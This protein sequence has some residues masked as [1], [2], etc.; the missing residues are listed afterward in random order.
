MAGLAPRV[1]YLAGFGFPVGGL[2]A[3]KPRVLRLGAE[4]L[5]STGRELVYV[6][7]S[8]GRQLTAVYRFPGQ[9][10][11]LEVLA[12]R[13]VLFVLCAWRGVYCL[14]LDQASRSVSQSDGDEEERGLPSPAVPVDP[15][16][17]VLPDA[18]LCAFTVMDGVLI[19]LAQG[20]AQ[21]KLQVF[22]CP[23]PG[24]ARPLDQIG[25]VQLSAC[26]PP[27]GSPGRPEAPSPRFLPVLCCVS[28][29]GCGAPHSL[30][31]GPPGSTL[32]GA[33]FGLLFGT[34][35]TLLESPVILCGLPD[36]QL[37]SVVLKT[38]VT[39]RSA[40]GD[41][42]ALVR[43]LHH[44]EEPVIF[45][46]ALRT[47][48]LP[49]DMEDTCCD[50]LVALGHRG[51]TLAIKASWDEAGSLVPE[52]REYRLPGP[53]LCAAC[54]EGGRVYHSTP[55]S[56]CLVDLARGGTPWLGEGA[57]VPPNGPGGLPSLLCPASLSVCSVVTLSVSPRLPE[58]G[59]ELLALSARGR[60][61][62]CRLEQS[63]EAPWPTRGT[64]AA[65]GRRMKDLLCGIGT[66]SERV[67]SL[68][69]AVDQRNRA[70]TCLN[71]AMNV[72]CALLSCR[73]GPRP[74]S[75][76]T[77][78]AWSRRE[79]RDVLTATCLLEN[80][81]GP[82]L[83]RGWALCV[84]VL[85]G[86]PAS[87]PEAAGSAVTYTIPVDQL[88]PGGRREVTLALG[89]GK[90]GMLD[91]PV[92]V[93]CALFY[94]LREVLGGALAPSGSSEDASW[95]GQEGICLPLS[96]HTVDL[97]QGLRFPGLATSL[98]QALGPS[99]PTLDPVDTFLEACHR[100]GSHPAQPESLR[101]KYLPPSVA[102]ITVSAELL[103]AAC[104][105]RSSGMS[106]SCAVLQ[107]LL[108]ENAVVDVVRARGLSSVQGVAP[109]GTD[110]RLTVR[111]VAVTGMCPAG[112]LQ[113]AEIQV[114]SRCLASVCGAHGA[115]VRRMQRGLHKGLT[116]DLL[117]PAAGPQSCPP[118]VKTHSLSSDKG[119]RPVLVVGQ[120][121]T[122]TSPG[123]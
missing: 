32:E 18:T 31:Q 64:S 51:R 121:V 91:L 72:S 62:T 1:D 97:L 106:L 17:C 113:A 86:A 104:G 24:Q 52:M 38:L 20:T 33:L 42:K 99:G 10:C 14:S 76:T 65:T 93:C 68:K 53:L 59:A 61:L 98:A 39:S 82:H 43:I 78:T 63:P 107:W 22:Q 117:A 50:C 81:S 56:L 58:G 15:D 114:E 108:A 40:P 11:H 55:S 34:D 70:L 92:T 90:D 16:A 115:I 26:T 3:G 46:G 112:P 13:R 29:P 96:E 89:P 8:E 73:E 123:Q 69:R 110:I 25:A 23:C 21:W 35:A 19:T 47:E 87:D 120:L 80:S 27:A 111:E 79:L 101:A 66:V 44:L 122:C 30:Q 88:G 37:C 12:L 95:D 7:D 94:S 41:P 5:L 36:G 45:I 119:L 85:P 74:I 2:A 6:Y 49:E 109:D 105:D 84:Q 75:C 48:P 67:S 100:P 28:P 71:E 116:R 118:G 4:I 54:G 102:A 103:R 83:G 60:L 57:D 9:V 77:T